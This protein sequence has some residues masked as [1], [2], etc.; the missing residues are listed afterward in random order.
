MPRLRTII[1]AISA[2]LFLAVLWSWCSANF[3]IRQAS[4]GIVLVYGEFAPMRNSTAIT[5][6]LQ[7]ARFYA[8]R[9]HRPN[10]SL[11][12]FE[13]VTDEYS[14]NFVVPYW[15]LLLITAP[16]PAYWLWLRKRTRSRRHNNA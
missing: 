13:Y 16:A 12:G 1:A 5:S 4:S 9:D 10:P 2:T 15:F 8:K 6:D 7:N 14:M 11:L 3:R